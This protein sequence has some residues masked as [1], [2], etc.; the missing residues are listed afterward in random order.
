MR[1]DR[2]TAVLRQERH[3]LLARY[4]GEKVSIAIF[5]VLK[6]IEQDIAWMDHKRTEERQ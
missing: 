3:W 2:A 6:R 1:D 4:D 5:V